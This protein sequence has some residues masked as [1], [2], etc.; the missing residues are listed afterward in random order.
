MAVGVGLSRSTPSRRADEPQART[1]LAG[2]RLSWL[3]DQRA[4][5]FALIGF[6][7]GIANLAIMWLMEDLGLGYIPSAAV[8]AVVTINGV[9]VAQERWV[10]HDLRSGARRLWWRFSRSAGFNAAESVV[11]T[12]ELWLVI[13]LFRLHG[14]DTVLAQCVLLLI[15]FSLRYVYHERVVYRQ[16]RRDSD[17][18][19]PT[20]VA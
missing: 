8:A 11:R 3:R 18:T 1:T 2:R 6:I 7:A 10:Y 15:G 12:G 9:F 16:I 19:H 17:G 4:P 14:H 20:A 13:S 5:G